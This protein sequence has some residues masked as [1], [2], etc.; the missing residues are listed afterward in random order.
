MDEKLK[1][2]LVDVVRAARLRLGRTQAKMAKTVGLRA[3]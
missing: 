2:A 3:T 1:H